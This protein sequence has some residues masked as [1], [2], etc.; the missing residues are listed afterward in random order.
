MGRVKESESS[1]AAFFSPTD[2]AAT[3][4]ASLSNLSPS[5]VLQA[6]RGESSGGRRPARL[7]VQLQF[8]LIVVLNFA[9][10]SLAHAFFFEWTNG[11][12]DTIA[13]RPESTSQITLL[14]GW[15]M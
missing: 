13:T 3:A 15:K 4:T 5:A 1:E 11:E 10:S 8:P 12:L 6:A 7:P 9:L 14:T 2:A